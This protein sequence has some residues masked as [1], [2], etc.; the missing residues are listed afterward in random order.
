MG[1]AFW[2]SG[3]VL[4]PVA[5]KPI[6]R[7]FSTV[8]GKFIRRTLNLTTFLR[9]QRANYNPEWAIFQGGVIN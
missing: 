8:I 6:G 7:C 5:V 1:P 3:P 2:V 9:R 4:T